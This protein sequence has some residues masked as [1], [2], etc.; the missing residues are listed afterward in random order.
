MRMRPLRPV[1][2]ADVPPLITRFTP[3]K[4]MP[5]GFST[6]LSRMPAS[7]GVSVNALKAEIAIENAIVSANCWYKR[8]VVPGKNATGT[9]T[10]PRTRAVAMTAPVT[11]PIASEAASGAGR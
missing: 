6:R 8:P 4:N 1:T 5:F 9:N 7:A 2:I 10:A 11:S 3:L